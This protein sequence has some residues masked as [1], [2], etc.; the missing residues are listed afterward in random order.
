MKLTELEPRFLRYETKRELMPFAE[1]PP[2]GDGP[3]AT[4]WREA[5]RVFMRYVNS[6]ED[7]QGIKFLCPKCFAENKGP[8]GTHVVICWSRS[9]G[10]PEH[11]EPKPGRW[12]LV[13]TGYND[14]T[15]NGDPPGNARSVLLTDGCRWHGFITNGSVE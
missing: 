13:G 15:L 4:V 7:A 3:P 6:I 5:D 11:A 2:I 14:L 12:S 8:I 10:V 9:R 1:G